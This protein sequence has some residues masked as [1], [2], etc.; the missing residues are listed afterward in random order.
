MSDPTV[1]GRSLARP[2]RRHPIVTLVD[3]IL[4]RPNVCLA[5]AILI[6]ML[7]EAAGWW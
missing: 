2:K 7:G 5:L 1:C 4:R 6:G 3:V